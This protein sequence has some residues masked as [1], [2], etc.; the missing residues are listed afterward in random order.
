MFSDKV[1]RDV[2]KERNE[3]HAMNSTK[4]RTPV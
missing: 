3:S 2:I 4:E 1:R